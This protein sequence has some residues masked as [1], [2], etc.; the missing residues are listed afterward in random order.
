VAGL[1]GATVGPDAADHI[2]PIDARL[3]GAMI[4]T[5]SKSISLA[6][7]TTLRVGRGV[8]VA[9]LDGAT[10]RF[11]TATIG[12]VGEDGTFRLD[13][14]ASLGSPVVDGLRGTLL[15]IVVAQNPT[16]AVGPTL[17]RPAL[18]SHGVQMSSNPK[19]EV[20]V[21]IRIP[22]DVL[23]EPR[24]AT[25]GAPEP[26]STGPQRRKPSEFLK[27][28]LTPRLDAFEPALFRDY[29]LDKVTVDVCVPQLPFRG[30]TLT[31]RRRDGRL[32]LSSQ[33]I[34]LSAPLPLSTFSF[35][36]AAPT[37]AQPDPQPTG[38]TNVEPASEGDL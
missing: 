14:A 2:V 38:E 12:L 27:E 6:G 4:A 20:D 13:R 10:I 33:R 19:N 22:K 9:S 30:R 23:V 29:Q 7:L 1:G 18:C 26:T 15:G 21:G 36:R 37:A 28:I 11:E 16:V 31:R 35:V 25:T 34:Q 5:S 32:M 3:A 8:A 17:I 24:A